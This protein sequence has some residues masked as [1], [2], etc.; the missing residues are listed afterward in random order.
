ML[1]GLLAVSGRDVETLVEVVSNECAAN[2]LL[3]DALGFIRE[4]Q[5]MLQPH[6]QS[7]M[8]ALSTSNPAE[9]ARRTAVADAV[10]AR[11]DFLKN[12]PALNLK[13][14]IINVGTDASTDVSVTMYEN[15]APNGQQ[16]TLSAEGETVDVIQGDY[17]NGMPL[18][19]AL[20]T[21]VVEPNEIR[22]ASVIMQTPDAENAA[23]E[24]ETFSG[25]NYYLFD[26][27]EPICP[28]PTPVERP[29]SGGGG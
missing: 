22:S 8:Q 18:Y 26:P 16:V 12:N 7:I 20:D 9:Y 21:A 2:G 14:A 10:L 5:E 3:A 4:R 17:E 25:F 11:I 15:G 1:S 24:T 6:Y 27:D 29:D 19:I 13:L 23:S 28:N